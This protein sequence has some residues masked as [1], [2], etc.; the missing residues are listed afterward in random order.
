MSNQVY[1]KITL[2]FWLVIGLTLFSSATV[3]AMGE[4]PHSPAKT[5]DFTLQDLEGNS[6]TL[7]AYRGKIVLL[8]FWASWC[9]PCREEMPSLQKMYS[10]WDKNKYVLL[11]VNVDEEREKLKEFAKKNGY[12]FPILINSGNKVAKKYE[13]RG[14][15]TTYLIDEKGR[16]VSKVVGSREWSVKEIKNLIKK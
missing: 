1:F 9:P 11:A 2:V 10:T 5:L 8:N 16:I 15:P 7:S 6:H 12:T 14:I 4:T 3:F 13:I